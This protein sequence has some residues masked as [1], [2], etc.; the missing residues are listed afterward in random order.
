MK[1]PTIEIRD[2]T[3]GTAG[4]EKCRGEGHGRHFVRQP[5]L[6]LKQACSAVSPCN[7]EDSEAF[8]WFTTRNNK[9]CEM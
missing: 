2:D 8:V 1:I 5:R 7:P 6:S 3:A 9:Q 4:T